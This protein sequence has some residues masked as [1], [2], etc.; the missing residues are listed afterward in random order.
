VTLARGIPVVIACGLLALTACA[1]GGSIGEGGA[2]GGSG[3][4]G[5]NGTTDAGSTTGVSVSTTGAGAGDQG[6]AMGTGGEPPSGGSGEGGGGPV[7]N[8]TAV[9]DCATA[10]PLPAIAGDEGNPMVVRMGDTSK[11][12]KIHIEEQDSSIGGED[13]SYTV[14]LT[15]PPG[16]NYDLK[17]RQGAQE[18]N[19]ECNAA[20]LNGTGTPESVS[21]SWGDD[22]GFGGEDDSVWLIIEVVYV[23][24]D[25]CGT[26]AQWSLQVRGN[27]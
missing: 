20:I 17:V 4:G 6:G 15:S 22:Q 14:S 1:E 27:T 13:I 9:E 24:G 11:W 19:P 25:D 3:L 5:A 7:C 10:E 12:F 18:G 2:G 8:Y 23:S 21:D 26:G 16:M